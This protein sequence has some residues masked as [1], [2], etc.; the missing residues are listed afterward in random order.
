M[1]RRIHGGD[2]AA[3]RAR[4]G[5]D[6]LDFSQNVS[7]L[8]LPPGVRCAIADGVEEAGRY[9]DPGCTALVQ[10]LA[11]HWAVPPAFVLCGNGACDLIFRFAL[12]ARPR[13]AVVPAPTF[14][15]YAR[16]LAAAGCT[17]EPAPLRWEEGLSAAPALL[18]AI[19]PGVEAVVLCQPNNPT[20]LCLAP[21][22][23]DEVIAACARVGAR[24]LVDECFLPFVEGEEELTLRTRLDALPH[25]TL[26]RA[27]TKI[28]AL[29]GLRLGVCLT[30]DG[31]L[32]HQMRAVGQPWPVSALAQLAGVAA[33]AD[34]DYPRQVRAL[35][36]RQRP[37]LRRQLAQLGFW[38]ADGRANFLFFRTGLP[39]LGRQ[40]AQRGILL[41]DVGEM[42]GLAPGDYRAAVRRGPDNR[43]LIAAM[44]EVL[45][46]PKT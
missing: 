42:P 32:L 25:V 45:A 44:K 5:R 15:E 24:L 23:L 18:R 41:R 4:Y 43:R 30:A 31:A 26:L 13:R 33:L 39:Q 29:A 19:R 16:A 46:W 20:G 9:P 37:W 28:Y 27:F 38:V 14:G 10:A 35:L 36:T 3:Y 17:V 1:D 12:A 7:P 34:T 8:G 22:E 6:P 40:L 2:W 11:R 21:R